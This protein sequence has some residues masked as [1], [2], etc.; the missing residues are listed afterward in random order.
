MEGQITDVGEQILPPQDM[1]VFNINN[2]KLLNF[3]K[4]QTGEALKME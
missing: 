2:F 3:K 1:S 4:L